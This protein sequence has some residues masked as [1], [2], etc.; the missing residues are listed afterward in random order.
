LLDYPFNNALEYVPLDEN[1]PP[2]REAG[3]FSKDG[4]LAYADGSMTLE[5]RSPIIF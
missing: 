1:V 5:K 3:S 4:K 2:T